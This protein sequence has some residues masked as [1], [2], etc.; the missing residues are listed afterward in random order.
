MMRKA[1]LGA[2]L[3]SL[4]TG[5][6]YGAEPVTVAGE[7]CGYAGGNTYTLLTAAGETVQ[8]D[9]GPKGGRLLWRTPLAVT[10]TYEERQGIPVLVMER[11]DYKEVDPY[12]EYAAAKNRHPAAAEAAVKA[13]SLRDP[14]Y[15]HSPVVS[16]N[17]SYYVNDQKKN[18]DLSA[19]EAVTAASVGARKDGEAVY[20]EGRAV[21]TIEPDTVMLFWDKAN[22]PVAVRMNG[23]YAPLG[24]RCTIYGTVVHENGEVLVSLDQLVSIE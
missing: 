6:A 21:E 24:Q 19:Y 10:G 17:P 11:I 5:A 2:V 15:D 22:Q 14:A 4:L 13:E 1:I 16:G 23:A 8:T 7:I 12:G 9:L 3:L 20:F 18:I